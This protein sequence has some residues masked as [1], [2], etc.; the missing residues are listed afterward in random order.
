MRPATMRPARRHAPRLRS[1]VWTSAAVGFWRGTLWLAVVV[2]ISVAGSG[3][4]V[5]LDHPQTDA[6]RPELTAKGD[7]LVTPRLAAMAPAASDLADAADAL[8]RNG[9][10]ALI[11]LRSQ[12][13]D[14]T[15]S[16][17][18]AGDEVIAA[19]ATLVSS[20]AAARDTLLEGTSLHSVGTADQDQIAQI[21][22]A[23]AAAASLPTSWANLAA[24]TPAPTAV[25]E[26]LAAH[27]GLVVQATD[28]ART[29]DWATALQRL[30][31][32]AEPV[33][34]VSGVS[35]QLKGKGFDV[36]TLDGWVLRLTD[37]DRALGTLY[38]LLE[39]SK[40]VMTA[41]ASAALENVNLAQA[42]LPPSTDALSVIVSDIGG[43]R[44]TEA[45]LEIDRARRAIGLAAGR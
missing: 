14:L 23:V 26:A 25:L 40:G 8:A 19:L 32:A 43:Q 35:A 11:H 24:A 45:L 34:R 27:D 4:V 2:V 42:A 38:T 20:A 13:V 3:L 39:A 28:A 9:R 31:D 36:T 41:E 22:A 44:I 6:G 33:A 5:A 37:Y 18:A 16:D 7:A 30:V 29:A 21:D 12:Q 17:L 1:M 15:R 10:D